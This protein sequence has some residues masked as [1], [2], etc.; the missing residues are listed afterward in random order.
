MYLLIYFYKYCIVERGIFFKNTPL[1][2]YN[3]G[4]T[5]TKRILM[6]AYGQKTLN[7]C[8]KKCLSHV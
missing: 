3:L 4:G 5:S 8:K 6:N 1:G 7:L 2:K